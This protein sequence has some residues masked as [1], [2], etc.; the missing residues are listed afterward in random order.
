MRA[1]IDLTHVP[2]KGATPALTD[3]VGGQVHVMV[4]NMITALPLVRAGKLRALAV[5]SAQRV[6]EMPDVPT[7]AESGY[8]GYE[9]AVWVGLVAPAKTPPAS[10][11]RLHADIAKVLA[12]PA[13]KKRIADMGGVTWEMTPAQF[14]AFIRAETEKWGAVVRQAGIRAE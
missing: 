7:V 13:V 2:Y 5:T 14:G 9:V 11:E 6:P 1:G 10:I 4:D 3:L 8:P 12:M